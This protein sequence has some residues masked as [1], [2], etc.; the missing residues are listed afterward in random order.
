VPKPKYRLEEVSRFRREQFRHDLTKTT[1]GKTLQVYLG[2]YTPRLECASSFPNSMRK[3]AHL[4]SDGGHSRL[5][6]QQVDTESAEPPSIVGLRFF[7]R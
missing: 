2:G 6:E 7:A 5:R 1:P 4:M 3:E